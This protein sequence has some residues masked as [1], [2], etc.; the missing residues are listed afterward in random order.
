MM[1]FMAIVAIGG[2]AGLA[3][4]VGYWYMTSRSLQNAADAA[5]ISGVLEI[6]RNNPDSIVSAA[7]NDAARN[8]A[9]PNDV[10]VNVPPVSGPNAGDASSVEVIIEQQRPLLF[11]RLV[12]DRMNQSVTIRVRAVASVHVPEDEDCVSSFTNNSDTVNA[13]G[14][15]RRDAAQ[16]LVDCLKASADTAAAPRARLAE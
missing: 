1:S 13:Q 15:G 10:G 12:M 8:G 5:A 6:I 4:D 11:S 9:D 14:Q 3:I 16:R 7:R 2:L